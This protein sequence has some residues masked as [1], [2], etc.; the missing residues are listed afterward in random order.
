MTAKRFIAVVNPHGGTRRGLKVLERVKP[1]F[2]AAGAKLDVHLTQCAGH[3]S[4][5]AQS[6]NLLGYDGFCVVGGDGTTHEVVDGLMRRGDEISIALGLIPAGTGNTLH[7]QVNCSDP[8]E[9]ARRIL[10]GQTRPLDVARVAMDDETVYCANIIG[11]G[12]IGDINGRAE[13]L[14]AGTSPICPIGPV[15]GRTDQTPSRQNCP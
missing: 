10:A 13:K 9:A 2:A 1:V 12:A 6:L 7:S 5:M 15:A 14:R 8:L 4:Q 11:W 3:A